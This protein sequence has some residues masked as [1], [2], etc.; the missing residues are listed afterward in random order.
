MVTVSRPSPLGL[1]AM[2]GKNSHVSLPLKGRI[3]SN[4][5][6][7]WRTATGGFVPHRRQSIPK[8]AEAILSGRFG[9]AA[10]PQRG[11]H[12]RQLR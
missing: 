4:A 12:D 7:R 9:E 1:S 3:Q 6:I 2:A 10:L 5:V 11:R 8:S